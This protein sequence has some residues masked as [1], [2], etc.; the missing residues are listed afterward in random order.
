MSKLLYAEKEYYTLVL[1]YYIIT[2]AVKTLL[3][4]L[5]Y[6]EH[7]KNKKRY[8]L[9]LLFRYIKTDNKRLDSNILLCNFRNKD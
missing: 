6:V 2:I 9:I 3:V 8:I 5:R 1:F 7:A 4:F